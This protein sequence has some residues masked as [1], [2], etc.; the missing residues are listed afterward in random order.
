M[1]R[2][3]ASLGAIVR[4]LAELGRPNTA[5]AT[6]RIAVLTD[7]A[8]L[9]YA[10][11]QAAGLSEAGHAVTLVYIEDR[12]GMFGGSR[13]DRDR[14]LEAARKTGVDVISIP[15]ASMRA[16]GKDARLLVRDLRRRAITAVV[17]QAHYDP[18]FAIAALRFPTALLLHDP[19]PHSGDTDSKL[20]WPGGLVAR[21]AELTATA[22]I[23]HSPALQDQLSGILKRAPVG[24]VP[25]GA[26]GDLPIPPLRETRSLLLIGRMY[27]YKGADTAVAALAL[28]RQH[29]PETVLVLA[30]RGPSAD[31]LA[32]AP[33]EGVAVL[34]RHQSEA[35]VDELFSSS[36]LVLLPYRDATQ[37]G[38]GLQA[39]ARGI[40]C[41]V[42]CVGALP[43]LMRPVAPDCVVPPGD[44]R[45][46]S[47]S[48]IR[49]LDHDAA[50]RREVQTHA[51]ASFAWPVVADTLVAELRRLDVL[52]RATLHESLSSSDDHPPRRT[53]VR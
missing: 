29:Y 23:L 39:I 24:Y 6:D 28:V 15:K 38:V 27:G 21:F 34:N 1:A 11:R 26:D 40:P 17:A 43:D 8:F 12:L 5:A 2:V 44:A 50:F 46:L 22:I 20:P 3:R 42:S 51:R 49:Y 36:R 25:H 37:S 19:S 18:R 4:G 53:P 48:I 31:A 33:P 41:V 13:D 7:V 14:F 10:S 32:G 52:R 16:L 30:G 9:R 47:K 45:A 35:E